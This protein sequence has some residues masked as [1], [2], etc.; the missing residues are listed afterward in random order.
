MPLH[1]TS[2][3]FHKTPHPDVVGNTKSSGSASEARPLV[4]RVR[5]RHHHYRPA[6]C[7]KCNGCGD[8]TVVVRAIQVLIKT[9][10]LERLGLSYEDQQKCNARGMKY[11][12]ID[13]TRTRE[14]T[15]ISDYAGCL[16]E[17][18]AMSFRMLRGN[19][20]NP[21]HFPPNFLKMALVCQ[22]ALRQT[23]CPVPPDVVYAFVLSLGHEP[24]SRTALRK[25]PKFHGSSS[26]V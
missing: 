10:A 18:S 2:S 12:E 11:W 24:V 22:N 9:A 6:S 20:L 5:A 23:A 15:E 14:G 1:R 21:L 16:A 4:L 13:S 19:P 17:D 3:G 25:G 26:I 7:P 8:R